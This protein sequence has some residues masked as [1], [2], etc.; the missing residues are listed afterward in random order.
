VSWLAR[1]EGCYR[2][3]STML[4]RPLFVR[5]W[6]FEYLTWTFKEGHRSASK[7]L[8]STHDERMKMFSPSELRKS[9]KGRFLSRD[10]QHHCE[11]GGHPVPLGSFLL[12]AQSSGS[13]QMLLVDLIVHCWRTW[14]QIIQWSKDLPI[15]SAAVLDRG[16]KISGRLNNWGKQDPMYALMVERHPEDRG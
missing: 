8:L 11:Q 12:G 1:Q 15:A 4:A 3:G 7:W 9:S 13:A 16:S 10:Y 2:T 6:K 14:D 5:W